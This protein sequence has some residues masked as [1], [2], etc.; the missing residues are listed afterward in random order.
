MLDGLMAL[1]YMKAMGA[2]GGDRVAAAAFAQARSDMWDGAPLIAHALLQTKADVGALGASGVQSTTGIGSV[3]ADFMAALR[4][5]SVVTRL[6]LRQVEPMLPMLTQTGPTRG[7]WVGEGRARSA[8]VG[9]YSRESLQ[10]KRVNALSVASAE[11]LQTPTLAG[12]AALLADLV[13]ACAEALDRAFLDRANAGD[14]A[15]PGSVTSTATPI[16]SSGTTIADLDADLQLAIAQLVAAGSNLASAFWIA[17]PMLAA[18]LGLAR[19]ADGAP[20]YPQ[21]GALGGVL[22]G[23]PCITSAAAQAENDSDGPSDLVLLDASQIAFADAP[24]DLRTSTSAMIELSAT[25]SGNTVAPAAASSAMVSMFQAEAVALLAGMSV[26]WKPRRDGVVQ[27]I[28]NVLPF[29]TS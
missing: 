2:C 15:T 26:N 7:Y 28:A 17:T 3:M 12:D 20:C 21:M 4:P 1:R 27:V 19:G 11:A 13:G 10:L 9:I 6:P 5:A 14:D 22:A 29:A 8:S 18:Q 25:P 16:P 23:L 24:P